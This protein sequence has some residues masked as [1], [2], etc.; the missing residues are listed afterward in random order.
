M[1]LE[2]ESMELLSKR[3]GIELFVTYDSREDNNPDEESGHFLQ[4]EFSFDGVDEDCPP[5]ICVYEDGT[6][7]F[8]HDATPYPVATNTKAQAREMMM[9]LNPSPVKVELITVEDFN[10]FI[11][12][13]RE[14]EDED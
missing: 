1:S 12:K 6:A 3:F 11:D 2:K 9:A 8:W 7:Q 5:I 14:E 4:C 13:I 10:G